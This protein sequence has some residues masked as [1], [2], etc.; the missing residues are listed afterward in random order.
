MVSVLL[1]CGGDG[2]KGLELLMVI[3]ATVYNS[4]EGSKKC[5]ANSLRGAWTCRAGSDRWEVEWS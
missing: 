1:S 5:D 4:E 3:A 2:L